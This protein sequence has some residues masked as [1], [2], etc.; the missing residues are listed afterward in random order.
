MKENARTRKSTS[1]FIFAVTYFVVACTPRPIGPSGR[2]AIG[3]TRL[4][5][6]R[7]SGYVRSRAKETRTI[8]RV[9]RRSSDVGI[10]HAC[11]KYTTTFSTTTFGNVVLKKT[12][13]FRKETV[14]EPTRLIAVHFDE[15]RTYLWP[16]ESVRRGNRE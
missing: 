16:F 1:S 10:R 12:I 7:N 8:Y 3:Y 2:S 13:F 4:Y 5:R 14:T 6:S 11:Y 9:S 15:K